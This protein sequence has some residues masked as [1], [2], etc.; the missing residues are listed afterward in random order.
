MHLGIKLHGTRTEMT[1]YCYLSYLCAHLRS[2]CFVFVPLNKTHLKAEK[3]K[4]RLHQY[5]AK[6]ESRSEPKT[7]DQSRKPQ[8]LCPKAL[9]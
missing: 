2:D 3:V 7:K 8:V 4:A 1:A 9:P 6:S 5:Q